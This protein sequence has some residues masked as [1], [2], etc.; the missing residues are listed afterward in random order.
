MPRQ[1]VIPPASLS[2]KPVRQQSPASACGTGDRLP[3]AAGQGCTRPVQLLG[4]MNAALGSG[5]ALPALQLRNQSAAE[6][7][8]L[9]KWDGECKAALGWTGCLLTSGTWLS[10][11]QWSVTEVHLRSRIMTRFLHSTPRISC[12]SHQVFSFALQQAKPRKFSTLSV[13]KR[14]RGKLQSEQRFLSSG[15]SVPNQLL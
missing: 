6:Q 12:I 1:E 14:P 10:A 5:N 11:W 8:K 4:V 3:T 9:H 2:Q 7:G 15:S 13:V